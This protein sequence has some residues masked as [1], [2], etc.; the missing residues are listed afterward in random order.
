[1]S[2]PAFAGRWNSLILPETD[3]LGSFSLAEKIRTRLGS[4]YL[5][6]IGHKTASFGV[7]AFKDGDDMSLGYSPSTAKRIR[8]SCPYCWKPIEMHATVHNPKPALSASRLPRS[9]GLPTL[10]EP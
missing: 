7:T 2:L 8:T 4:G 10:R 5:G 1:M 3:I 9:M 6:K